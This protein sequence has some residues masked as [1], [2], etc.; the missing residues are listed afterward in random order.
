MNNHENCSLVH[1]KFI[2]THWSIQPKLCGNFSPN[3]TSHR[4][5]QY[6]YSLVMAPH[7][8]CLFPSLRIRWKGRIWRFLNIQT[9]CDTATE[10]SPQQIIRCVQQQNRYWN[11]CPNRKGVF[12]NG[13]GHHQ[14][15]F[16]VVSFT[17]SVS[18]LFNQAWLF[19]NKHAV[20]ICPNYRNVHKICCRQCENLF[21]SGFDVN[22]LQGRTVE[23]WCWSA[24]LG[25]ASH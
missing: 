3:T 1:G 5:F 15:K 10:I 7:Y 17:I 22:L 20:Y 13:F 9:E 25:L 4:Y 11:K 23:N 24:G 12:Q 21:L 16:S 8:F 2:T 6:P 14:S 18:I 19:A